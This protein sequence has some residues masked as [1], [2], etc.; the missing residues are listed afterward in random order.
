MDF[1]PQPQKI[2]YKDD[3][4]KITYKTNIILTNTKPEALLYA[5]MLQKTIESETGLSLIIRRGTSRAGDIVIKEDNSLENSHY[6]I[7]VSS[8]IIV[9]LGGDDEA[10]CNGVQTLKQII[11]RFG[12]RVR[13]L[14]IEDYPHMQNRAYYLDVSRGR[15]P[16]LEA[17]K[18]Y[19]DLLC[20]YKINQWQLYIEHTY[21]FRDLSEAWRDDEPLTAE[22][23]MEL[24][25]YCNARHIELVP[26][27]ATFGHMYKILST[28]T[29]CDMCEKEDSEK[30]EFKYTDTMAHHTLNVSNDKVMDFAKNLITE[31]KALFTSKKFNI[32]ADETFDLGK[33]RSKALA[34]EKTVRNLYLSHV[35]ELCE[36]LV[37]QGITPMFWGDI[38]WSFPDACKELPKETIC[39]NWGYLP[40]QREDEMRGI[41]ETGTTQYACP[42]VCGWNRWIPLIYNSYCNISIMSKHAKKFSAIGLLNTDW[43]DYAHINDPRLCVPG[44]IYGAAFSWNADDVV[45]ENTNKLISFFEY[46]DRTEKFVDTLVEISDHE[47]FGWYNAVKWHE[48]KDPDE[49]KKIFEEVTISDADKANEAILKAEDNM[50]EVIKNLPK[51]NKEIFGVVSTVA[52]GI[53][54][55]NNIGKYIASKEYGMDI[56]T[57]DA[58]VL[59]EELENWFAYYKRVW[60]Q[61]S[62]E[63]GIARL[64]KVIVAYADY[65]RDRKSL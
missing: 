33:Y 30:A 18:K 60:R 14:E 1:L 11:K 61:I 49:K 7:D 4:F 9:L 62:T 39:L 15:I 53:I 58:Y 16:T 27:L 32:C 46:G 34:E 57:K 20:E 29:C 37:E 55:W 52:D 19:A 44:I 47:I 23:I 36:F 38:M 10:V 17:L 26:S 51:D 25:A 13:G 48:E 45:F 28:K 50:A 12:A 64:T 43:G 59:A 21:L 54:I 3:V 5:K 40:K 22:E 6:T 63:N 24:D 56:A 2:T 35:R 41:A 31:Y 65:L 42:G 8:N